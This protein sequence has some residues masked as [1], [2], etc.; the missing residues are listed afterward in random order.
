MTWRDVWYQT[1]WLVGITAGVV[2]AVVGLSGAVLSYEQTILEALNPKLMRV[3]P[4]GRAAR[5][6]HE[7]VAKA[8]EAFPDKTVSAITLASGADESARVVVNERG[9]GGP[10][11]RRGT[12]V[13]VDP[14]TGAMLG[15]ELRGDKALH[16]VEDVHRRLASADT[17][18]LIV[19][20]STALLLLLAGTGLYLRWPTVASTL[21]VWFTFRTSL[22]G[23]TFLRHL[24]AI[25]GTWVLLFYLLASLTGL[26]W[27]FEWYRDGLFAMTGAPRPQGSGAAPAAA[28]QSRAA[29]ESAT[30][31]GASAARYDSSARP[32][33]ATDDGPQIAA[34]W[35]VFES[36]V[37]A[38]RTATLTLPK[39]GD[40]RF[41]VRY[42]DVDPVHERAYN[43]I[44]IEGAT[45]AKHE[46]YDDKPG[47]HKL[48][49]SMFVLHKGSFFGWAGTLLMMLAS[50]A[51]PLF[52]VTGW[53]LYLDRRKRKARARERAASGVSAPG[54]ARENS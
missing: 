25:V 4:A 30:A 13:F 18:K 23:R 28:P 14:Y 19:G 49:S 2:L 15:S 31:R 29:N 40:T 32:K 39:P 54:Y 27:S 10:G 24:H 50:L 5:S 42:L 36:N 37:P 20:I 21:R 17:G 52:A 9:A 11:N 48:M 26:Y 46:R 12:T 1:H 51:M 38:F 47:G 41:E 43:R 16:V 8:R 33:A 7:L 22:K 35:A 3:E 44:T 45:V 53:M 6:P 34:A